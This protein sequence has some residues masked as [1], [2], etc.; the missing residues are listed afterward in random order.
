[1]IKLTLRLNKLIEQVTYTH[2]ELYF[3]LSSKRQARKI[4]SKLYKRVERNAVNFLPTFLLGNSRDCKKGPDKN[5]FVSAP[6][7]VITI[8]TK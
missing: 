6:L 7:C 4:V 3:E 8:I 1:M 2:E 5:N